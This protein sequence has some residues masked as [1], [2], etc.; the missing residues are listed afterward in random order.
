MSGTALGLRVDAVGLCCPVGMYAEAACAAMR[1]GIA[2]IDEL[3]ELVGLDADGE[4]IYGSVLSVVDA[5]SQR[6]RA[7]AHLERAL[8]DLARRVPQL[9]LAR[10]PAILVT[11]DGR[12]KTERALLDLMPNRD[13]TATLRGGSQTAFEALV[14]AARWIA[15]GSTHVLVCAVDCLLGAIE[16]HALRRA[17]RL[18]GPGNP[19]GIIPGE[20]A[21]C[22]LVSAFDAR[23]E[24]LEVVSHAGAHEPATL[25][26]DVPVRGVGLTE[27]IRSALVAARVDMDRVDWQLVNHADETLF[28][29][30]H[31][32]ALARV[33]RAPRPDMPTWQSAQFIGDVGAAS[34]FVEIIWAMQ[35]WARGYA[36]GQVALCTCSDPSGPRAAVV[37][38]NVSTR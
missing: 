27:A 12:P 1:A 14:A 9:A 34:G 19:H 17:G 29:K 38:R 21:A 30:E 18:R 3:D 22:L 2:V 6:D 37:V 5:K 16:L 23:S 28:V 25:H 7:T 10:C 35:A 31:D 11:R 32:M 8:H 33:L 26:N 20:A 13:L 36:P 24:G 4:S 15:E